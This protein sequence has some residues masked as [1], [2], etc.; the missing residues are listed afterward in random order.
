MAIGVIPWFSQPLQRLMV[1][2]Y[3]VS[4]SLNLNLA[5]ETPISLTPHLPFGILSRR[6]RA[7]QATS[8][9]RQSA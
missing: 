7:V 6:I 2:V 3:T 8:I 5:R 4:K 1:Y 9:T